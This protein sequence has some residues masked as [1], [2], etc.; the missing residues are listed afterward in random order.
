MC[1]CVCV[2][3]C[4]CS[5]TYMFFVKIN[6]DHMRHNNSTYFDQIYI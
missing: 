5:V 6:I 2:C 3:V 1:V 4:V